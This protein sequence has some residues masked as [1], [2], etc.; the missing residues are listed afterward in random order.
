[1]LVIRMPCIGYPENTTNAQV[2]FWGGLSLNSVD[3]LVSVTAW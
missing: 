2:T 3:E 1:M